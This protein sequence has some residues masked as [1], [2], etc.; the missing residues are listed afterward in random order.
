M[1]GPED[2]KEKDWAE[3]CAEKM[4]RKG[5]KAIQRWRWEYNKRRCLQYWDPSWY[6]FPGPSGGYCGDRTNGGYQL[7][8]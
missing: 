4:Q 1:F 2:K 8:S 6:N 7:T 5:P 3:S